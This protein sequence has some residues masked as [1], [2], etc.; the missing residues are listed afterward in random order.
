MKYITA[1][2]PNDPGK[3][4]MEVDS[5][6]RNLEVEE[7]EGIELVRNNLKSKGWTVDK[8][9]TEEGYLL[10][11]KGNRKWV[12]LV[13]RAYEQVEEKIPLAP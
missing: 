8:D 1:V 13:A 6:K 9:L 10:A 5:G 4:N 12:I 2:D 7:I 11:Q 3:G